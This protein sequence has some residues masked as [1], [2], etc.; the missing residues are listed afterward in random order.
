VH[1]EDKGVY[2][3][4]LL[5]KVDAVPASQID[6]SQEIAH[7][8]YAGTSPIPHHTHKLC[9]CSIGGCGAGVSPGNLVKGGRQLATDRHTAL[10]LRYPAHK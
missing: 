7:Q 4:E 5:S 1:V 6:Q 8:I 9:Y 2:R 3:L 10:G